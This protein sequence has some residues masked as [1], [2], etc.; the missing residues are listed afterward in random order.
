MLSRRLINSYSAKVIHRPPIYFTRPIEYYLHIT[1]T[2]S[3]MPER[4]SLGTFARVHQVWS[5]ERWDDGFFNNKGR[6]LVYYPACS[7]TL[8]E[9]YAL[10]SY[11]VFEYYA[12][13]PVPNSMVI[14]HKNGDKSDD[15]LSNLAL[16]TKKEHDTLH[17]VENRRG[18][19]QNCENCGN[20]FYK[21][22]WRMNSGHAGRFC[23]KKCY[24][25]RNK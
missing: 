12:C 11:A 7:R 25:D 15:R 16:M 10:R 6:F 3:T 18:S 23:G 9:G 19:Y 8:Y 2:L 5:P 13:A 24:Y 14:H 17:Q 1:H 4:T 21:P 22:K 20:E